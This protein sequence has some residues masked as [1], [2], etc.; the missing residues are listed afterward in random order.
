[1]GMTTVQTG[2]MNHPSI[3]RAR[4]EP[5]LVISSRVIM[6]TAY[7]AFIF[8]MATM[9]VLTI[10]MKMPDTSAVSRATSSVV[11]IW[12]GDRLG[13]SG[14]FSELYIYKR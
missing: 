7:P 10:L 4:V 5:A 1:M 11:S 6:A 8:V 14:Y 2:L 9:I 13:T 12:M 3:V